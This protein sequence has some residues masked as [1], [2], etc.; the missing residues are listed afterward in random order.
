MVPEEILAYSCTI[1]VKPERH[2]SSGC[3]CLQ[4][5][6][7]NWGATLFTY[8]RPPIDGT[9]NVSLASDN[10]ALLWLDGN[11]LINNS[12]VVVHLSGSL[13]VHLSKIYLIYIFSFIKKLF[14]RSVAF[15]SL[16]CCSVSAHCLMTCTQT[17]C[18][19]HFHHFHICGQSLLPPMCCLHWFPLLAA[20]VCN[21]N[22]AALDPARVCMIS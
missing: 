22:P 16:F 4:Q 8:V 6:Y 12:G 7:S 17:L 14:S 13:D 18:C 2:V 21:R 20:S 19:P 3:C 9:Y 10:G 5:S 11:M 15:S 1:S